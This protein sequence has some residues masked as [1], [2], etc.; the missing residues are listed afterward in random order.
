[1]DNKTNQIKTDA[2]ISKMNKNELYE[3]CKTQQEDLK[4]LK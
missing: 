1:M 4:F 3:S 2:V